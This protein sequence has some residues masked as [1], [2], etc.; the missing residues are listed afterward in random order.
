MIQDLFQQAQLAE[1]AYADLLNYTTNQPFTDDDDVIA[2]LIASG[3][4]T[5][6]VSEFVKQW[7]IV[8][9]QPDT[10]N[11]FSATLLERLYADG[12]RSCLLPPHLT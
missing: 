8:D 6:Q 10:S 11:G 3:M 5:M 4:S 7:R 12:V 2:A 1:A 9:Q